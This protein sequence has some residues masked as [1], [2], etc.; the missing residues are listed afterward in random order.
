MPYDGET[1]SDQCSPR[2]ATPSPEIVNGLKN[3]RQFVIS[4]EEFPPESSKSGNPTGVVELAGVGWNW[5]P[6]AGRR[7]KTGDNR[8]KR[9]DSQKS[10]NVASGLVG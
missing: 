5:L 3:R 2:S 6:L 7:D 10:V 4:F 1:T 9:A 8:S